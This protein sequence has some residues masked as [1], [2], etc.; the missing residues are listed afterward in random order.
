[1]EPFGDLNSNTNNNFT[2]T[3]NIQTGQTQRGRCEHDAIHPRL[4]KKHQNRAV[5]C[6]SCGK[7]FDSTSL[8]EIFKHYANVRHTNCF[9]QCHYCGG[10]VHQYKYITDI[11]TY[12]SCARSIESIDK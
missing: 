8:H 6:L 7:I 10:G 4:I 12:H 9:G 5:E 2:K 1:M 3:N 11:Y